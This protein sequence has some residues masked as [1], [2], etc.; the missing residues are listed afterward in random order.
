VLDSP[1]SKLTDLMME[2]VEEQR[3]PI[4]RMLMKLVLSSMRKSVRKKAGFDIGAVAP[5]EGVTKS[6]TPALFGARPCCRSP[7]PPPLSPPALLA[8]APWC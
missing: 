1:F 6:H 7:P 4:P 3:L 5:L 8:L 2:I